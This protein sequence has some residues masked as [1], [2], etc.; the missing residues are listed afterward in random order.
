MSEI[1]DMNSQITDKWFVINKHKKLT[2][3]KVEAGK[4]RLISWRGMRAVG[5][6]NATEQGQDYKAERIAEKQGAKNHVSS[7]SESSGDERA[8]PLKVHVEATEE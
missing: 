7:S 4:I 3:R 1:W 2:G 8:G 6:A 5:G